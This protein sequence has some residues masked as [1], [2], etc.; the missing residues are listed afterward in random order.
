MIGFLIVGV[1]LLI[2]AYYSPRLG[3]PPPLQT[4]MS[5]VGWICIV[6]ALILLIALLLN[7]PFAFGPIR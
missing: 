4:I 5:I 6:I 2:L 1:I 3:M 7:I